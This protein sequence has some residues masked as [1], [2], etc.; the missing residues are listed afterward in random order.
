MPRRSANMHAAP[1]PVAARAAGHRAPTRFRGSMAAMRVPAIALL[2]VASLALAG[3]CDNES[4]S[5]PSPQATPAPAPTREPAPPPAPPPL[6]EFIVDSNNVA[7]GKEH[8]PTAPPGLTDRVATLLGSAAIDGR[9]PDVVIMRNL[10]PSQVA[11]VLAALRRAS[12]TGANIKTEARDGTTQKLAVSFAMRV[13]D[14]AT[15]AWIA[16]DDS[17]SVWPA[18]GG[19]AKRVIRGLAG[20]DMTLGL[21]AIR[22][23]EGCSASEMVFGSDE[24]KTWGLV[25]DLATGALQAPGAR[26]SAAILV[27]SATPGRP[28]EL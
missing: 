10:K 11:G 8:V 25:F 2:L 7:V 19:V 13:P 1:N 4:K 16:K 22:A 9:T 15:V 27:T 24:A 5:S 20:P 28:V 23:R 6:P 14:C 21:E 18:G 26:A 17:I 3:G 12:A